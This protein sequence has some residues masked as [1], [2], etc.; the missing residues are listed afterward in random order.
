MIALSAYCTAKITI[1]EQVV[2]FRVTLHIYQGRTN[3]E[4]D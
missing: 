4:I 2:T 1:Y 3:I